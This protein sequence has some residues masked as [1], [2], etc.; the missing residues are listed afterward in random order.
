MDDIVSATIIAF[1][2][3]VPS[4]AP[5]PSTERLSQSL[6]SLSTALADQRDALQRW[7]VALAD[8]SDKMRAI[9]SNASAEALTSRGS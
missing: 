6:Q 1:P 5:Q 4:P 7:R 8:L 2:V 9:S 3:R